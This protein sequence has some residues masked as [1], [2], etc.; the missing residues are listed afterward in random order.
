MSNTGQET[1][2]VEWKKLNWKKI[3]KSIFKLQKRIYQASI[4]GN[5]KQ[6]RR[7][8]KTMLR[9]RNAKLLAT[10]QVTQDNSGKK[11][12]GVTE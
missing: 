10:R 1:E 4:S 7:L 5:I 12:A 8:Q 3:Q 2:T 9:S 11:T 6:L